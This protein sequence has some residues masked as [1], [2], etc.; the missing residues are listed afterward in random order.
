MKGKVV[1]MTV[2]LAMVIGSVG[3][4]Q[5]QDRSKARELF[6]QGFQHYNLGEYQQ[7]LAAFREAYRNYEDPSFLFNIAQSERQLGHKAEAVRS[8][9]AYLANAT[10]AENREEVRA[11]ISRLEREIADEKQTRSAP[12]EGMREPVTPAPREAAATPHA[13]TPPLG[14]RPAT[15]TGLG[16]AETLGLTARPPTRTPAFKKWWV[17]TLVSGVVV[18][19]VAA[20][21]AVGLTRTNTPTADT[22]L[23]VTHPF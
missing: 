8:Y 19:G 5:A 22:S 11:L 7:A 1:A 14:A 20:G 6:R 16:G 2:A 17:W 12:P 18:G 3:A 13:A 21:L 10:H 9:R 23:G 15:A 4:A